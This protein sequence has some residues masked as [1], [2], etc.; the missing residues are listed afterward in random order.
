M[1]GDVS[2]QADFTTAPTFPQ[3]LERLHAERHTGP[4]VIHF[5]QGQPNVIEIPSAPTRIALD[6]PD[7][8]A[9]T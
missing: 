9:Q 8:R 6:K 4:V 3:L 7:R 2:L 5:A 1:I